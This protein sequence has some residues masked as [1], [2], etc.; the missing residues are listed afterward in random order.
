VFVFCAEQKVLPTYSHADA[1][2]CSLNGRQDDGI[3][4]LPRMNGLDGFT[5]LQSTPLDLVLISV[6]QC[7]Q[8]H[9]R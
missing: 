9:Q 7:Y 5:N 2:A 8:C 4:A 1:N 3:L 6:N